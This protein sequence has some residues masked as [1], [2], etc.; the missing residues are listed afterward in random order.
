MF[1][2]ILHV[3]TELEF[4]P[5]AFA[6]NLSA[7]ALLVVQ[8]FELNLD[9]ILYITFLFCKVQETALNSRSVFKTH[10]TEHRLSKHTDF[11]F[12]FKSILNFR[13]RTFWPQN[14][15]FDSFP[16]QAGHLV[17]LQGNQRKNN[18]TNCVNN[19]SFTMSK[20]VQHKRPVM[21]NV[22]LSPDPVSDRDD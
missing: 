5:T 9:V 19:F 12:T 15:S 8:T 11:V 21:V 20:N 2:L 18:K 3:R 7:V 14:Y 10:L 13:V 6:V 22:K 4:L 17:F 16:V 1:K